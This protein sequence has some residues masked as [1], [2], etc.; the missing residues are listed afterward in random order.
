MLG[1]MQDVA[2]AFYYREHFGFRWPLWKSNPDDATRMAEALVAVAAADGEL[3]GPERDWVT[4]YFAVKGYGPKVFDA[5]QQAA[6]RPVE[7]LV[8]MMQQ[9]TLTFAG[10][11]LLYDAIRACSADGDYHEGERAAI[12]ALGKA[13]GIAD[14]V[15][16]QIEGLVE[17]EEAQK[18]KRIALLMPEGHPNLDDRYQP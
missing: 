13:L 18:A 4:G 1:N 2:S 9:G 11:I 7:E 14:D 12:H 6:P 5:I 17:E 3:S 15:I 16:A 8:E 10:R